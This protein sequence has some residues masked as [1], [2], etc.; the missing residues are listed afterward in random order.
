LNLFIFRTVVFQKSNWNVSPCNQEGVDLATKG[1][2]CLASERLYACETKYPPC[3]QA[4]S[5][6]SVS[7]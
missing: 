5:F 7:G 4:R 6:T 2:G 3:Q 1:F